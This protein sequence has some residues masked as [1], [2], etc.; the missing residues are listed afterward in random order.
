MTDWLCSWLRVKGL[1]LRR[2][3]L[4]SKGCWVAEQQ[5][6]PAWDGLNQEGPLSQMHSD[7]GSGESA[8]LGL[9]GF[10]IWE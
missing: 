10:S 7:M 8:T 4:F 9:L 5:E 3:L 6:G 1:R 2:K